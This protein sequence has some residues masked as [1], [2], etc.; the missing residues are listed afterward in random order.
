MLGEFFD[1]PV[2]E[3]RFESVAHPEAWRLADLASVRGQVI[4][5]GTLAPA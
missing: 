2:D 4:T 1:G 5:F 3:L